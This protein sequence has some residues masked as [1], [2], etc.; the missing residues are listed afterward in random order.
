MS[1]FSDTWISEKDARTR[2]E[3]FT[4]ETMNARASK[5]GKQLADFVVCQNGQECF[6]HTQLTINGQYGPYNVVT[7]ERERFVVGAV[8]V[9]EHMD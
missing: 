5:N 8:N 9:T 3:G 7:R 2:Y 1:S 4:F 6:R